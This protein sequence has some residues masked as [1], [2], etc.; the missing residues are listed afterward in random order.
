VNVPIQQDNVDL[1][2]A[3]STPE[4]VNAVASEARPWARR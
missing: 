1:L 2:F 3:S 4:T